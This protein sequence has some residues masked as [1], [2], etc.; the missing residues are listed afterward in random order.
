[1]REPRRTSTRHT[2]TQTRGEKEREKKFEL[3]RAAGS[4]KTDSLSTREHCGAHTMVFVAVHSDPVFAVV[5]ALLSYVLLGVVVGVVVGHKS[6]QSRHQHD[7]AVD[8]RVG[9][10]DVSFS[11]VGSTELVRESL[12][13]S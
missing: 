9:F 8:S 2:R 12:K 5:P 1:V 7:D 10:R 13:Y 3:L 6:E 4:S 11:N